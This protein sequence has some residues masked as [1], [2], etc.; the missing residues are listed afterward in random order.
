M[1]SKLKLSNQLKNVY[2]VII[3]NVSSEVV[4]VV[5]WASDDT[6]QSGAVQ[7]QP[8]TAVALISR[9]PR[10]GIHA[11]PVKQLWINKYSD[12]FLHLV[13]PLEG[14]FVGVGVRA[15]ESGRVDIR[16]RLRSSKLVEIAGINQSSCA[17]SRNQ[18]YFSS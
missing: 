12:T 6:L 8:L 1:I 10:C 16:V 7:R 14:Q 17:R 13:S 5:T 18:K 11:S 9:P 15:A 4:D 2:L 3:V